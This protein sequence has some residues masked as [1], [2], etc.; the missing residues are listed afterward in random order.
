MGKSSFTKVPL[1]HKTYT[2]FPEDA[3]CALKE[4]FA[5]FVK[6]A[7]LPKE[8]PQS[9]LFANETYLVSFSVPLL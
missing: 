2:L 5:L 6:L 1:V 3:N 8:V 7:T 4:I 9:M